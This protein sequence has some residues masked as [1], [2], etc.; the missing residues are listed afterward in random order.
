MFTRIKPVIF[1]FSKKPEIT[2]GLDEE[3][4]KEEWQ[5]IIGLINK[6]ARDKSQALYINDKGEL[7]IKVKNHLWLQEM[8]FYKEDIK[9]AVLKNKT[10]KSIKLIT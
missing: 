1:K 5:D 8:S 4:I 6:S 2:R 10:I 3:R 9:K 7:V